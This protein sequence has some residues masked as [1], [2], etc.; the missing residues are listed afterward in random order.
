MVATMSR[1]TSLR[2]ALLMVLVPAVI[3]IVNALMRIRRVTRGEAGALEI[4]RRRGEEHLYNQRSDFLT[5][6]GSFFGLILGYVGG[7]R[8]CLANAPFL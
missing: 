7:V 8:S 5:E 2:A 6:L 3:Q 4:L 1:V